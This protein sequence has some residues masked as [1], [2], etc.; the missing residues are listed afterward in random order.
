VLSVQSL[1]QEVPAL[2]IA[3]STVS[4]SDLTVTLA[5]L[6]PCRAFTVMPDVGLASVVPG[7]G[8]IRRYL[9]ATEAGLLLTD[10]GFSWTAF[11]LVPELQAVVSSA[12]TA[13]MTAGAA[14][15]LTWCPG[16]GRLD[17]AR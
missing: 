8:V 10:C 3:P 6:A 16:C 12:T 7:A 13:S 9:A 17:D 15:R 11:G 5:S 2:F 4:P 14:A 1:C